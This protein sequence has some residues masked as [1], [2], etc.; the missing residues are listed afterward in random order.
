MLF[1]A[2]LVVFLLTP[3]IGKAFNI[4]DPLF[5]W[6]ARHI[7]TNPTNP[8]AM[9]LN[10]YGTEMPVSEVNKNPPLVSY[11]IA[12]AASVLGWSEPA[13]H[14]AFIFPAVA[15]AV[16]TYLLARRFCERPLLATLVA[17]LTPVFLVSSLTVMSDILMMSFYVFAVYFWIRGVDERKPT[18]LALAAFLIAVAVL[19]KY[20]ALVLIPLL[21]GRRPHARNGVSVGRCCTC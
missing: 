10:W 20:S 15:V 6:V 5:I 4:D 14:V 21:L 16:G 8:F 11:Y 2:M 1:I 12:L 19:T 13:L 9:T 3:F 7:Q 17:V 18:A